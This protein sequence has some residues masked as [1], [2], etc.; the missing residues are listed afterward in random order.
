MQLGV[1]IGCGMAFVETNIHKDEISTE[2]YK[3]LVGQIMG[4]FLRASTTILIS[5]RAKPWN[6][7]NS[8]NR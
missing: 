1:D 3:A 5:S 2:E 8:R 7:L 4:I 6:N